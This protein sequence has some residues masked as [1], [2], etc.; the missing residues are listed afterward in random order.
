MEGLRIPII[1]AANDLYL[2]CAA[3]SICSM[4]DTIQYMKYISF[5]LAWTPGICVE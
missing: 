1:M 2:P 3:V 5:T 4:I